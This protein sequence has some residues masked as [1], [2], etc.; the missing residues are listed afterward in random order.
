MEN[1]VR[2]TTSE[3][4]KETA[5]VEAFSDG[6]FAIAITLLVLDIRVPTTEQADATGLLAQLLH[7]WPNFLAFVASFFFILVMWIN[8]HRLFT[9]IR[10]SDN[11]LLL[12]NGLLLFGVILVPFPTA[13]V[14]EYLQHP[15]EAIAVMVYTGWF[16]MI[17]IFFN[18]LWR[19]AAHNNRLFTEKTDRALAASISRQYS[20]GIPLYL[21]ALLLA[22]VSPLL[23]ILFSLALAVFFALPSK[24]ITQLANSEK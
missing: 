14:A 9:V 21:V 12:L 8:H 13:L 2:R 18:M 3:S 1:P 22:P 4:E 24:S 16:L 11:N 19:Y 5:R 23:S 6:V 17:A 15:D 20:Y 7:L 10:R